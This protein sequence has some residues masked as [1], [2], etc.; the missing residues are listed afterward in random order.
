MTLIRLCVGVMLKKLYKNHIDIAN[1]HTEKFSIYIYIY[2]YIDRERERERVASIK[3][4]TI[5][6]KSLNGK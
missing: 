3:I 5:L 4:R 2:I 6:R 1:A